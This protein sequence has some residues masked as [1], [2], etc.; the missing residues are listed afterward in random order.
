MTQSLSPILAAPSFGCRKVPRW[1]AGQEG[2]QSRKPRL[3]FQKLLLQSE[4]ATE[5]RD[6]WAGRAG[7]RLLWLLLSL[8]TS[9]AATFPEVQG[10]HS[11]PDEGGFWTSLRLTT[12]CSRADT[13]ALLSCLCS[14]WLWQEKQLWIWGC[15]TLRWTDLRDQIIALGWGWRGQMLSV[16]QSRTSRL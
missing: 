14:L 2:V 11:S 12:N 13:S 9:K 6:P 15:L 8:Q 1:G 7:E 3:D 4:Q 5:D 16:C 10:T